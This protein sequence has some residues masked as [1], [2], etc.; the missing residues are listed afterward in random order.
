MK[1]KDE[2]GDRMKGYEGVETKRRLDATLPICARIDGRSF[3]RFT[4]GFERP[5]D[6]RIAAAMRAACKRLVNETNALIGFVQSDEISLIWQA[7]E[8]SQIFF[9]GKVQ[10]M[11][12]VL[13]SI[14]TSEFT[15][16]MYETAPDVVRTRRP[17]L[18]LRQSKP[19]GP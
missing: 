14:A 16:S 7:D 13:A 10:K 17:V 4:R 8:G 19:R 15:F 11:A 9:D 6:Q 3:S 5:F 18:L 2:L 1:T 12:S